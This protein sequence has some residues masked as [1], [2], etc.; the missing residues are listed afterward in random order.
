MDI[1]VG[2]LSNLHWLWIVAIVVGVMAIAGLA[3]RRALAR[4][5]TANLTGR[6]VA[7]NSAR[8]LAKAILVTGAL[9]ALVFALLDIRWRKVWR[10]VPQRGIEV[11][12]VL[13]VSRSMLAE[14]TSPNRLQRAKQQ[15]GDMLEA[16]AGDRVGLVAFAGDSQ[17]VVPLTS[18]FHDFKQTLAEVGPHEVNRG[19]S[20]LGDA[21]NLAA[22]GVLGTTGEHNETVVFTDGEDQESEPVNAA[23]QLYEKQ[24]IR[25]FAVGLGDMDEGA[26]IPVQQ[27]GRGRSYLEH[28]GQ[29]VWSKLNG[30]TLEQV[31][32]ATG[33]AYIPAGT[34]QVDMAQVYHAYVGQVD[35]QDF[36]AA[37]INSYISRFQWFVGLALALLVLDTLLPS[38]SRARVAAKSSKRRSFA[39]FASVLN[40][41]ANRVRRPKRRVVGVTCLAVII[42]LPQFAFAAQPADLVQRGNE[43][44]RAGNVEQALADYEQAAQIAPHLPELLYNQAVAQYRSGQYEQARQ[45]FA[46]TAAKADAQLDAKARYN[47]AN[48]DYAEAVQLADKDKPAA[49]DRLKSAICHYRNA[50]AGDPTETDCRAT[51]QLPHILTERL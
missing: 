12:F 27:A 22:E 44:L 34:K 15:I 40:A 46:Q 23:R 41:L 35:E 25:I 49:I 20:R 51:A 38:V 14:D 36:A 24:G 19:G 9:V 26:R 50:L 7:G 42:A 39:P 8:R 11:M 30:A 16:M 13:D 3:R 48:C 43:A 21:L 2:N 6:L 18:H 45:L 31:A 17:Q 1:Q 47:L 4:F 37:R 29:Q 10:D 5:A 33:G 32:L 28:E